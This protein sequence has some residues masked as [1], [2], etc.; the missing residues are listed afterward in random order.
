MH[1]TRCRCRTDSTTNSSMYMS[2]CRPRRWYVRTGSRNNRAPP[3]CILKETNRRIASSF[4]LFSKRTK[5]DSS[6]RGRSCALASMCV[7]WG[8]KR[9]HCHYLPYPNDSGCAICMIRSGETWLAYVYVASLSTWLMDRK[10]P[11]GMVYN[12]KYSNCM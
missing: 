6:S 1:H 12:N 11:L 3:C 7:G 2:F 10:H 9:L 5:R 4:S 8:P